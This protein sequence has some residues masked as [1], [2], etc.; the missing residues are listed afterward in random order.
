MIFRTLHVRL[1]ATLRPSTV[2]HYRHTVRMFMI[3]VR[4]GATEIR[5]AS[6]L[7]RNPYMLGL[8]YLWTEQGSSSQLP[9]SASSRAGHRLRLRRIFELMRLQ[10]T[11]SGGPH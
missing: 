4:Q 7:K 2:D 3:Y 11:V 9:L 1:P 5:C 10:L 6:E 8:Q